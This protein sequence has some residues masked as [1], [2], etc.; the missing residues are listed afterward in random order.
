MWKGLLLTCGLFVLL[1]IIGWVIMDNVAY[2]L[3]SQTELEQETVDAINNI[4][5]SWGEINWFVIAL[6]IFFIIVSVPIILVNK[7]SNIDL[8]YSDTIDE[9]LPEWKSMEESREDPIAILKR[10]YANGEINSFE[11]T[12]KMSRL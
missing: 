7:F 9:N 1:M 6:F 3:E 12:E 8:N 5:E 4:R 2:Q 10:R 11:Y